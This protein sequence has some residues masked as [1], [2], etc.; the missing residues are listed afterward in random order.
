MSNASIEEL[1][2]IDICA[3]AATVYEPQPRIWS[4][5]TWLCPQCKKPNGAAVARCECGITR[6]GLPEFGKPLIIETVN[7][8]SLSTTLSVMRPDDDPGGPPELLEALAILFFPSVLFWM[9]GIKLAAVLIH[10]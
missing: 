10:G 6:D 9:A 2:R 4:G 8:S 5:G 3:L 1:S 7:E